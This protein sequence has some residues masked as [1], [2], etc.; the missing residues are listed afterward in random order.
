MFRDS[1]KRNKSYVVKVSNLRK[2]IDILFAERKDFNSVTGY[3]DVKL[4]FYN[5]TLI[6]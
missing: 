1:N 4:C 5:H 2:F 3:D 6:R